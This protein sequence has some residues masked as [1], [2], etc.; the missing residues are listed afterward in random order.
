MSDVTRLGVVASRLNPGPRGVGFG[1]R[2]FS[3]EVTRA[4]R[5]GGPGPYDA[6]C[7]A[8]KNWVLC[9]VA[10]VPPSPG[11]PSGGQTACP[12][13]PRS[14]Q[15][16]REQQ[17]NLGDV[18]SL[19]G[20]ASHSALEMSFSVLRTSLAQAGLQPLFRVWGSGCPPLWGPGALTRAL[21]QAGGPSCHQA[22]ADTQPQRASGLTWTP[23]GPFTAEAPGGCACLSHRTVPAAPLAGTG[24]SQLL[25]WP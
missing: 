23:A 21:P 15:V 6:G 3:H 11:H 17:P 8:G 25:P 4:G 1:V 9:L 5:P 16:L 24:Q 20:G 14:D 2:G 18:G 13:D 10:T 19:F 12:G 7:G 22:R